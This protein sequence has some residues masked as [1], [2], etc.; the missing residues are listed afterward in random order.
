MNKY[1]IIE[2]LKNSYG[3]FINYIAYLDEGQ[4]TKAEPDKWTAGQQLDH[5]CRSVKPLHLA[6]LL[7]SFVLKLMFSTS[8][9]PSKTYEGLI[10]KYKVKLGE[11]GKATGRFIPKTIAFKQ[12]E[13][14]T[15]DLY[16]MVDKLTQQLNHFTES[17]LDTVLL[18]HPL[19]GKLTLREMMYFTIY[20]AKHHED[21]IK[22]AVSAWKA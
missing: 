13:P 12:K 14:L 10:T 2:N 19:L 21:N 20:H 5:I 7:P 1:E 22:R 4:F 16:N 17:E 6:L 9:R 8:N 15:K 18:P 11:G 3:S